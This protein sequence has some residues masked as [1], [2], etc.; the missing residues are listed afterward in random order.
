MLTNGVRP[1]FGPASP[2]SRSRDAYV[3]FE[4]PNTPTQPGTQCTPRFSALPTAVEIEDVVERSR[5]TADFGRCHGVIPDLDELESV[6][7]WY[8]VSRSRT[9]DAQA[10]CMATEIEDGLDLPAI[11]LACFAQEPNL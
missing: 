6:T 7:P 2:A 10:H 1:D 8:T 5:A 3:G 9:S 4:E 11:L